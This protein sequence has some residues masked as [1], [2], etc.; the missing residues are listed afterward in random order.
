MWEAIGLFIEKD[1]GQS[2]WLN[3]EIYLLVDCS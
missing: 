3:D 2:P 1:K